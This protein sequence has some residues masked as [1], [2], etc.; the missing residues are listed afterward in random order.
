MH[1]F[2]SILCHTPIFLSARYFHGNFSPG[3]FFLKGAI[4]ECPKIFF[5]LIEYFFISIFVILIKHFNCF[6]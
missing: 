3:S 1:F 6:F 2:K 4:S 5:L